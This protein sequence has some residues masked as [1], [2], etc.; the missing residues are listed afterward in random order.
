MAIRRK[1]KKNLGEI[2][3]ASLS[4]VAFLLLVFFL[5]TT[6]FDMKQGLG[7]VLPKLQDPTTQQEVRLAYQNRCFVNISPQGKVRMRTWH[8]DKSVE[9][10]EIIPVSQL[11]FLVKKKIRKNPETTIKLTTAR[12]A[13]YEY[14]IAAL[15]QLQLAGAEGIILKQE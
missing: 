11:Q 6:K 4:D 3:T 10:D 8:A 12:T 14:M 13:K 2:P 15:E 1:R 9:T 5:S 7:L